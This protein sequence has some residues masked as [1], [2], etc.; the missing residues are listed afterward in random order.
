MPFAGYL[1]VLFGVTRHS[2][3]HAHPKSNTKN[4]STTIFEPT[5]FRSNRHMVGI[6]DNSHYIVIWSA[7]GVLL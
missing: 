1:G 5:I 2:K 4:I 7:V 3:Q 6:L